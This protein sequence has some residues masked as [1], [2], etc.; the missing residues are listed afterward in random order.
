[1]SAIFSPKNTQPPENINHQKRQNQT[2]PTETFTHQ[3][4]V[5]HV[6]ILGR[7]NVKEKSAQHGHTQTY[8]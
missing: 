4:S 6:S 3:M 2:L 5:S 8:T 7:L 1:M